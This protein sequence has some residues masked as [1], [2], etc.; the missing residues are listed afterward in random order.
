MG[1]DDLHRLAVGFQGSALFHSALKLGVFNALGASEKS[2]AELAKILST[3]E[4]A[5]E[6]AL[7]ALVSMGVLGKAADKYSNGADAAAF[8]VEDAPEYRG[9]ILKHVANTWEDWAELTDTWRT[10]AARCLR[11]EGSIPKDPQGVE[12][13][14][15]GMEN[16]T[17]EMAPALAA[18]LPLEGCRS[19]LDLGGGPGNYVLEFAK[20][21]PEAEVVHFDLEVTS[22]IASRFIKGKP[23]SERIELVAG[24]FMKDDLGEGYDF[25]WV[26]QVLH[27][28]SEVDAKGLVGRIGEALVPGGKLC[29]HEHFLNEDKISPP[30]AVLFGVHMLAVTPGGRSY[31]FEEVERWCLDAGL[32]IAERIDYGGFSRVLVVEKI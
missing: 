20:R 29:V 15:I 1:F 32:T 23:G 2:A 4:R 6:I 12:N 21:C 13:F 30:T 18:R 31:S 25:V 10:G 9:A 22:A 11:K 5:T 14:I 8:L 28:F 17:R 16:I 24:D 7:N 19:I 26:S 3:D 27:M